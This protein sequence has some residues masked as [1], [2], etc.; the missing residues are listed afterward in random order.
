VELGLT[1]AELVVLR[2]AAALHDIGKMAI[3]EAILDKRGALSDTDWAL[4][5][6]HTMIGE[7]I[8][9]AAPALESSAKLVRSSH[10]RMDGTGYPDGLAATDIPLGSRI[11]LVADA[12]DAMRSERSYGATFSETDALAELRRCA[13]TQFDPTVVAAFERVIARQSVPA[14]H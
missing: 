3:P 9:A 8:L 2:H 6:R 5:R 14:V 12:F 13:G 1:R 4:I 11:I 10:E 7:R